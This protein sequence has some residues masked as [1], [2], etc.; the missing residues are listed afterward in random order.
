MMMSDIRNAV[1]DEKMTYRY[2]VSTVFSVEF[3]AEA[4]D[5]IFRL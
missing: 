3:I 4:I 1:F 2:E 5:H